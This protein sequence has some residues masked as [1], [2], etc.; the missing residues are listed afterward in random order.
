MSFIGLQES[1]H[2]SKLCKYFETINIRPLNPKVMASNMHLLEF[3]KN[4][5]RTN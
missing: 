4:N 2:A 5:A 1:F 3:K